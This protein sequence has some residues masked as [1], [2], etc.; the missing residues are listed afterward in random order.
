MG[1]GTQITAK[2]RALF[3]VTP[4][5]QP[6]RRRWLLAGTDI[7]LTLT[8]LIVIAV[9]ASMLIR[10][11]DGAVL[12]KAGLSSFVAESSAADAPLLRE[13]APSRQSALD[14]ARLHARPGY[15]CRQHP[16]VISETPGSCPICG[17]P[18]LW[19]EAGAVNGDLDKQAEVVSGQQR[20]KRVRLFG[21][22]WVDRLLVKPGA[23]VQK[24]E[25]LLELYASGLIESSE[26]QEELV[27]LYA[28]VA[29]R[30][31]A[32]HVD[33]EKFVSSDTVAM[34]IEDHGSLWLKA[35]LNAEEAQRVKMGQAVELLQPADSNAVVM[36]EVDEVVP[37]HAAQGEAIAWLRFDENPLP[38]GQG[39]A[40]IRI[41]ARPGMIS[42]AGDL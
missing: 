23:Q 30:V 12:V 5:G 3:A 39:V 2:W 27:R 16:E 28:P 32:I 34:E 37:S 31:L 4:Q 33:E 24:G 10:Y 19:S 7:F 41:H 18:L 25:L 42:Q 14:H 11:G 1:K 35:G 22:G 8:V 20:L 13:K 21:A 6:L 40:T 29:G 26:R 17:E 15:R 36:G 9:L 38:P